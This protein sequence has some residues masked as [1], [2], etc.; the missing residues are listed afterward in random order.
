VKPERARVE[1][2]L[3][4]SELDM[5]KGQVGREP[6]ARRSRPGLS[7]VS[8][9]PAVGERGTATAIATSTAA[10]TA[11]AAAGATAG[12]G[13]ALAGDA[14]GGSGRRTV[15]ITGRGAER[16]NPRLE[17]GAR[18]RPE[19]RRHERSDFRPDRTAL[20]AVVLCLAL[21]VLAA[22]SAHGAT[23]HATRGSHAATHSAVR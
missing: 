12:P 22:T 15:T 2:W 14:G 11:G 21:L 13:T 4:G 7:P 23:L 9:A 19:R 8:A 17:A 18:S 1:A 20:W 3:D 16:Y 5:F 10:S 6:Q